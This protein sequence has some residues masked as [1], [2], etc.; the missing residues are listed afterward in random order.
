MG[1]RRV[2]DG[3]VSAR[4][5]KTTAAEEQSEKVADVAAKPIFKSV[6]DVMAERE[7]MDAGDEE[8]RD[9]ISDDDDENAG[10]DEH[11]REVDGAPIDLTRLKAV[12]DVSGTLTLHL[13]DSLSGKVEAVYQP[14][15]EE[16]QQKT[17]DSEV[18]MS[19]TESAPAS[20]AA[21]VVTE[22]VVPA[23]SKVASNKEVAA[24][25]TQ[26]PVPAPKEKKDIDMFADDDSE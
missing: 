24:Q 22:A 1:F 12:K 11:E 26:S 4:H 7:A 15:F 16:Q 13:V 21:V 2:F 20:A 25:P 14:V 23:Q 3:V 10:D 5:K 9:M 17:E 18:E 8:A 19:V 6:E